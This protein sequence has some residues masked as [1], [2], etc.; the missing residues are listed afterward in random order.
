M[1]HESFGDLKRDHL[2]LMA[3]LESVAR[4]DLDKGSLETRREEIFE[5][6]CVLGAL[7]E[8]EF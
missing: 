3:Q 5:D 2:D 6:I 4:E 7:E 1:A 8:D